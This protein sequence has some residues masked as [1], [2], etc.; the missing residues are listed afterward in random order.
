MFPFPPT[1]FFIGS[2]LVGAHYL[3]VYR[4]TD[5]CSKKYYSPLSLSLRCKQDMNVFISVIKKKN[6]SATEKHSNEGRLPIETTLLPAS[7]I[8]CQILRGPGVWHS[9]TSTHSSGLRCRL[10]VFDYFLPCD[11]SLSTAELWWEKC[12][13]FF[14]ECTHKMKELCVF[15]FLKKNHTHAKV[16]RGRPSALFIS[17]CVCNPLKP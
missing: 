5:W 1:P 17:R 11:F 8:D 16:G 7:Q 3:Q 4:Q 13:S 14:R 2:E 9:K 10:E 12:L 15:V 6:S